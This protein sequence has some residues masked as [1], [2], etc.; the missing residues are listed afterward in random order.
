MSKSLR[1]LALVAS[2]AAMLGLAMSTTD[3][4]AQSAPTALAAF[5]ISVGLPDEA[6]YG[7]IRIATI[8]VDTG[9]APHLVSAEGEMPDPH[10]PA[11]VAWYDFQHFPGMGGAPGGGAQHGA[12]CAR[13]LQR[14]GAIRGHA[15]SRPRRVCASG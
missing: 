5:T 4:R 15:V 7:R 14:H 10:G 3:G 9:I 13:G 11:D 1:R 8:G 2:M 6:T 12:L